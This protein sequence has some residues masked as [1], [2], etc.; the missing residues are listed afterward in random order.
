MSSW[1][2][3]SP[4]S[5]GPADQLIGSMT[6]VIGSYGSENPVT[7]NV[8]SFSRDARGDV[9]IL[10]AD[11]LNGINPVKSELMTIAPLN[12][13]IHD[14]L[15]HISNN[16]GLKALAIARV[17]AYDNAKLQGFISLA[18]SLSLADTMLIKSAFALAQLGLTAVK[19]VKKDPRMLSNVVQQSLWKLRK[20]LSGKQTRDS[21]KQVLTGLATVNSA[22]MEWKYGWKPM[23]NDIKAVST[24]STRLMNLH[25]DLVKGTRV[26]GRAIR[27]DSDTYKKTDISVLDSYS[28]LWGNYTF[29]CSR[30][31]KTTAVASIVRKLNSSSSYLDTSWFN[32]LGV[33]IE[34]N[35]LSPSLKSA[36]QL[37]SLTFV[38]DWFWNVSQLLE[39]TQWLKTPVGTDFVS[40]N[41][42]Y[43]QKIETTLTGSLTTKKLA[44]GIYVSEGGGRKVTYTRAPDSLTGGPLF[45]VPPLKI[46]FEGSK[47]WSMAQIVFQ[48]LVG[49]IR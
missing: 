40:S 29:E 35:G 15:T 27:V 38:T 19:T 42:T 12:Y 43:S 41:S 26:Y 11:S 49:K 30:T 8:T 5:L 48:R 20:A 34:L 39:S 31:T 47:L 21:W 25:E 10:K 13:Y 6:D 23:L 28:A 36:W 3:R 9:V 45:Y 33:V 16:S 24:A 44:S 32:N 2:N 1:S 18:E 46:P 14:R 17:P 22:N 7:H 37:S 4:V